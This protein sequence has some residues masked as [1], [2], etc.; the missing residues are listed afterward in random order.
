[1]CL[2]VI[3]CWHRGEAIQSNGYHHQD[4]Y[5]GE[6]LTAADRCKNQFSCDQCDLKFANPDELKIHEDRHH[7][8]K[9]I[10]LRSMQLEI[11]KPL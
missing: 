3:V 10:Q 5:I 6:L 4:S 7:N 11:R 9:P 8:E 1:M 2:F